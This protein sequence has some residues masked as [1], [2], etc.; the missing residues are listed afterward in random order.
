[1][2]GRLVVN[3]ILDLGN[4]EDFAVSEGD[5]LA[6]LVGGGHDLLPPDLGDAGGLQHFGGDGVV[7]GVIALKSDALVK[8]GV[9]RGG[10]GGEFIVEPVVEALGV[11]NGQYV[12]GG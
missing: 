4:D 5:A 8:G 10:G 9:Y 6:K 12:C 2:A 7:V 11:D 3:G 1:E